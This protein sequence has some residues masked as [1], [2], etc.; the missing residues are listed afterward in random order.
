MTMVPMHRKCP[1]C[2]RKYL[3]NPD[4][5]KMRCPYC[6]SLGKAEVGEVSWKKIGDIMK[7]K[8]DK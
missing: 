6:G 8:K 1:R 7:S 2:K 5:G 4:V 3:W